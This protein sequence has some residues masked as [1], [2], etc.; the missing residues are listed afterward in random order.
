MKPLNIKQMEEADRPR[1]KLLSLG[2]GSLSD[3]ELL[4]I[5]LRTGNRHLS[6]IGLA[7]HL[8]KTFGGS[9]AQM[10]QRSIHDLTTI[11]GIGP[12][13]AIEIVAALEIGKRRIAETNQ[14]CPSITSSREAYWAIAPVLMDLPTE[15]FW[16]ITCS[17]SGKVTDKVKISAGGLHATVVDLKVLMR[18]VLSRSASNIVVAHNHPSGNPKPSTEDI[19]LTNKIKD[20]CKLMDVSL[21]DHIIVAGNI[22]TS[23]ADEG[24]L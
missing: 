6:A 10:A 23:F 9:L 8:L 1:E 19:K 2:T 22:Y 18:N 15:E 14:E 5:L 17:R 13:K 16:L 3:A 7:Q 4:A 11:N 12:A 20:A 21:L 24:L